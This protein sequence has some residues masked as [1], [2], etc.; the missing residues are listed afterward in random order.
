[1]IIA[2][3]DWPSGATELAGAITYREPTILLPESPSPGAR[4]GMM[5]IH[6][7][8]LA[9]MWFGNLV[10]PPWW[11]D[12]WLKE[13]FA[14]W[15]TYQVMTQLEPD[16]GW[17]VALVER[18]LLAMRLDSL[19][20][21]RAINESVARNADIR[22]A[23]DAITYSKGAAVIGMVDSYFGPE[24]FRPALGR[25]VAEFADGVADSDDFFRVIGEVSGE[26]RLTEV[27]KSFVGQ[28]GVPLVSATLAC[29]EGGRGVILSQSRYAPLGSSVDPK[30]RNW[31][32]PVRMRY[33]L[34]D[35]S[36]GEAAVILEGDTFVDFGNVD[37]P[38]WVMPNAGGAGYFR[39][40]LDDASWSALADVFPELPQTEALSVI[41]SARAAFEAGESDATA[42]L[43]LLEKGVQSPHR[44]V[45]EQALD[46]YRGAKRLLTSDDQTAFAAYA[47]AITRPRT[48]TAEGELQSRLIAFLSG[49]SED[50]SIR[51][52]LAGQAAAFLE[53]GGRDEVLASD[54]Y[55]AALTAFVREGGESA[56]TR[57]MAA[58]DE[59]DEARFAASSA[60]AL[61]AVEEPEL[62]A[63]VRDYALSEA[64]GPREA[65]TILSRLMRV[66][67]NQAET[68][69]WIQDNFDRILAKVPRQWGRRTPNYAASFCTLEQADDAKVFFES[70]AEKVPG[71]ERALN[72]SLE[73]IRLCAA[74]KSAKA[75][76][77]AA[78]IR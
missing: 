73:S 10:T 23:Y 30:S 27:F 54:L 26:P 47:R 31:A 5:S 71:Y 62:V 46:G 38:V 75:G 15:G 60:A 74:F 18:G 45:V 56:V 11:N 61:A 77:L 72:Q 20:A 55:L 7:H 24:K 66:E 34:P 67:A 44:R 51:Q 19:A 32:A 1:D 37:C 14:T 59:I 39:W 69:V 22:N 6:A 70:V 42:L 12:L 4:R 25:Y 9:H 13:A 48:V 8:E 65:S 29:D 64:V 40:S 3:P 57:L 52:Q 17:D 36:V 58:R 49:T 16:E 28:N 35:G 33:G 2:A 53:S 68:W 21:A 41:D 63:L 78:A 43:A 50:R 76:E